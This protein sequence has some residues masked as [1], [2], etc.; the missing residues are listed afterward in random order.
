MIHFNIKKFV[1][2]L[3]KERGLPGASGQPSKHSYRFHSTPQGWFFFLLTFLIMVAATTSGHNLLYLLVCV[4]LGVFIVM[5][6]MAVMNLRSLHV[7]RE[8]PEEIYAETPHL[9]EI[10]VSNPREIMDSFSLKIREIPNR[11]GSVEGEVFLPLVEKGKESSKEYRLRVSRRGWHELHGME[12][13][14]RFPFG[15]WERSRTFLSPQTLLAFPRVFHSWSEARATLQ[16]DGEFS[17][18]RLGKGDELLNFRNYE[19]GDPIRWIHWKNTAKT[20]RLTVALFHHPENRQAIVSLR[21]RYS[22]WDGDTFDE[23][24]E[25][26][27]SWSATAVHRLLEKGVAVGYR[28]EVAQIPPSSGESHKRR[29][30]THL[31]LLE[32]EWQESH[33]GE[34]HAERHSDSGDI[35]YIEAFPTGV[36]IHSGMQEVDFVGGDR[37]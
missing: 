37:G 11:E 33:G 16:L 24:V 21:T 26:A 20:D 12:I 27:I 23:H 9:V 34:S 30:L 6:N 32:V 3:T 25:E 15:F 36:R 14:T 7:T 1:N 19:P 29:I 18:R 31:A 8:L 13:Q 10:R 35:I 17:G 2:E 28:D 22:K 4:F 5:G